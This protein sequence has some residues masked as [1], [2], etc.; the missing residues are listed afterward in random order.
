[1]IKQRSNLLKPNRVLI[2]INNQWKDPECAYISEDSDFKKII[3]LMKSWGIPFDIIR[4]DDQVMN[5]YNF[6]D[7]FNRPLYGSIIWLANIENYYEKNKLAPLEIAVKKFNIGFIA[8]GNTIRHS[9]I[10]DLLGLELLG[11]MRNVR[12]LSISVNKKSEL[13]YEINSELF[14][15]IKYNNFIFVKLA[16]ATSLA[17]IGL[18]PVFTIKEMNPINFSIYIG[19]DS[20]TILDSQNERIWLRNALIAT[21]GYM[22]MKSWAN[23][24]ILRMDDPGSA[25]NSWLNIWHYPTLNAEIIRKYILKPLEQHKAVLSV[26]VNP[27]FINDKKRIIEPSWKQKFVDEF[28]TL[29]DYASTKTGLD[30][31]VSKELLE[32]QSHG[33]THMQPDL[34]SEPGPWWGSPIDKQRSKEEWYREFYDGIRKKDIPAAEQLHR[35][36]ISRQW[37]TEQFGQTPMAFIPGGLG[38][39]KNSMSNTYKLAAKSGFGWLEGYL[40][41]DIVVQGWAFNGSKDV[42]LFK[43]IPPDGHDFGVIKQP[44]ALYKYLRKNNKDTYIGYNSYIAHIHSNP[45]VFM[46]DSICVKINWD[47]S[48]IKSGKVKNSNWSLYLSKWLIRTFNTKE[49]SI[50]TDDI[51]YTGEFV[52]KINLSFSENSDKCLI[53]FIKKWK[54]QP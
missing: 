25:Q 36:N 43:S 19:I 13:N 50:T 46:T 2:I 44:D 37:I 33:W 34:D 23:N 15:D 52:S 1:V 6:V 3:I 16:G 29:Q 27:G 53:R 11:E 10:Q 17:N 30:E 8:L 20:D 51:Q 26:F 12:P 22:L 38:I 32:I 49:Y 5:I 54:N 28:G 47:N 18:N 7:I 4:L 21:K 24:T 42:P 48:Y 39:S 14:Q 41:N 9:T 31:G 45:E 40:G 35:M